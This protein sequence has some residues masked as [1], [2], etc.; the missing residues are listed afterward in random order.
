M[1]DYA[2]A[3][4]LIYRAMGFPMDFFPVLFV[5][6]RVVG[7][8]AHWRQM[9]LQEG[10][11]KIWR[12]RQVYVGPGKRDYVPVEQRATVEGLRQTP[13]AVEHGGITKRTMLASFKGKARL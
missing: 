1:A 10:G 6:P 8:L 7:W 11:V 9:M 2:A 4:G 12:P 13:S 5:V 3:S